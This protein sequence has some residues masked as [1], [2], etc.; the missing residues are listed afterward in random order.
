MLAQNITNMVNRQLI[1]KKCDLF[2]SISI[3]LPLSFATLF[4]VEMTPG[5][6]RSN[7]QTHLLSLLRRTDSFART[8]SHL[9]TT[10][11]CGLLILNV[12]QCRNNG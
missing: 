10:Q 1:K 11:I 9:H 8:P 5:S 4:F 2:I 6:L 12:L 7:S 3:L